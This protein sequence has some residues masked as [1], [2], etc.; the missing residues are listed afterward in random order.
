MA[1]ARDEDDGWFG[2]R[3]CDLMSDVFRTCYGVNQQLR[4]FV[5]NVLKEGGGVSCTIL[6]MD[7]L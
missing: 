4:G 2:G 6:A 1:G 5:G 7:D 3:H